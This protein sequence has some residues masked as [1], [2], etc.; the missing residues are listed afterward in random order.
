MSRTLAGSPAR[1][2]R[3]GREARSPPDR[4]DLRSRYCVLTV[5]CWGAEVGVQRARC[6][7]QSSRATREDCGPPV[8]NT[9]G[10]QLSCYRDKC[11]ENLLCIVPRLCIVHRR[12]NLWIVNHERTLSRRDNRC[13]GTVT[14]RSEYTP[15]HDRVDKDELV[16]GDGRVPPRKT[17]LSTSRGADSLSR[18]EH[19]SQQETE[20]SRA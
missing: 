13:Y 7:L 14:A 4:E 16:V 20:T 3:G 1:S 17:V 12:V 18:A 8:L 19:Q 9:G 2:P 5:C 15:L 10:P 11:R 6:R